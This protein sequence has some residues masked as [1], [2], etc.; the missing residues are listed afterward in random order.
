MNVKSSMIDVNQDSSNYIRKFNNQSD[1][2][3]PT[4]AIAVKYIKPTKPSDVVSKYYF[5]HSV[6]PTFFP[7]TKPAFQTQKYGTTPTRKQ[8][9]KLNPQVK[10]GYASLINSMTETSKSIGVKTGVNNLVVNTKRRRYNYEPYQKTGDM[11]LHMLGLKHSN[12][13][14]IV[15]F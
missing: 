3:L 15:P 10:A 1:T 2:G 11:N 5:G 13:Y 14:E 6:L 8:T 12:S 4:Q 7:D 9:V